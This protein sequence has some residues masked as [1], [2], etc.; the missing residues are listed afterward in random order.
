MSGISYIKRITGASNPIVHIITS[1][2][3][4]TAVAANYIANQ[5]SNIAAVNEGAFSW[6]SGDL[7]LLQASDG[8]SWCITNYSSSTTLVTTITPFSSSVNP[9]TL[10]ASFTLTAAQFNG[11]YA[12]PVS[13][14]A[15]A[16]S[17][18]L[19]LVDRV[20][21]ELVFGTAQFASGGI[22]GFQYGNTAHL[23]GTL[24]TNTE[25]AADFTGAA[26]STVYNF[27]IASGAG[28]QILSSKDNNAIY[29]SNQT[30]AF[31]TGDS[32][33][34]GIIQYRLFTV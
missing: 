21:L 27:V 20:T 17:G 26:A 13:V 1:D 10:S 28:S 29:I 12:T 15:A 5:A 32:T 3:T 7:V 25:A 14:L 6:M 31:T 19:T 24:A 4:A 9:P 18:I 11:M 22:V 16:G 30:G 2:T 23:A 34:K 8:D 33:F